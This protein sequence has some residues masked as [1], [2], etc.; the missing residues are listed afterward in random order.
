MLVPPTAMLA[1]AKPLVSTGVAAATIKHCEPTLLVAPVRP[2]MSAAALVLAAVP[3]Q[4]PTVGVAAVVMSTVMVQ[5]VW[6]LVMVRLATVMVLAPAVAVTVP[7]AQVPPTFGTAAILRPDCSVSIK[8]T[9]WVGLPAG[10]VSVKVKVLVPPTAIVVGRKPLVSTGVA[11]VTVTQAPEAGAA[12][13]VKLGVMAEVMLLVPVMLTLVLAANGQAP[14]V[15]VAE[16]RTGTV[17]VQL[18]CAAPIW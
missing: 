17:T 2:V 16:T 12:P 6:T 11:A 9:V 3:G 5:V 14:M 7:P 15:G 18:V 13:L 4:A 1:G 8:L 10:W